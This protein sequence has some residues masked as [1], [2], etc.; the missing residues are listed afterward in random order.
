MHVLEV[1][2]TFIHSFAA[3]FV[4]DKNRELTESQTQNLMQIL[5]LELVQ[6]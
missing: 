3:C 6:Y 1:K 2:R 5:M 4:L